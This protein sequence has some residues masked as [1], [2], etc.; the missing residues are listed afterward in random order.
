[1]TSELI[2]VLKNYCSALHTDYV[3]EYNNKAA[4]NKNADYVKNDKGLI[5]I[6]SIKSGEYTLP[7]V[8]GSSRNYFFRKDVKFEI[9]F[10]RFSTTVTPSVDINHT[11]YDQNVDL[12]IEKTTRAI[13]DRIESD[14][15]FPFIEG[16]NKALKVT[17]DTLP[18]VYPDKSVFNSNEVAVILNLTIKQKATCLRSLK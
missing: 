9:W 8:K 18:F 12:R 16:I 1:M 11:S 15:V 14:V 7:S 2:E 13:R 3:V 17:I 4:M 6:K 10:C 5:F